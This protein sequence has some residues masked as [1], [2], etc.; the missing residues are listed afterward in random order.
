MVIAGQLTVRAGG[1]EFQLRPFDSC[2]IPAGE[3]REVVNTSN[4]VATMLVVM[5]YPPA[6]L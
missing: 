4:S 6:T 2:M 5:P 1:E 3:M